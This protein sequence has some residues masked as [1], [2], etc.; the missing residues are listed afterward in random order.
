[1]ADED[2]AVIVGVTRY[3]HMGDLGGPENDARAMIEWL[4]DPTGGAVPHE[5]VY[6]VCTGQFTGSGERERPN[7]RDACAPFEALRAL[8]RPDGQPGRIGRRLYIFFAGHGVASDPRDPALLMANAKWMAWGHSVSGTMV[9]DDFIRG[10]H[11]EEIV[12]LMD[13][14]EDDLGMALPHVLPWQ[15]LAAEGDGSTRYLYGFATQFKCPAREQEVDGKCRGVFTTALLR[16]LRAGPVSSASIQAVVASYMQELLGGH[17]QVPVFHPGGEP[18][19]LGTPTELPV[20]EISVEAPVGDSGLAA[21]SVSNGDGTPP[22]ARRELAPGEVW[23]LALEP[24]LYE[25]VR[26]DNA[27]KELVKIP[28]DT[29]VEL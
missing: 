3:P 7:Q 23:E 1:M 22:F 14:C 18:L 6:A 25:I 29:H 2:H 4:E 28:D 26:E 15:K 12:L 21:V 10:G 17:P 24:K 13:C 16:A 20:L 27:K 8:V 5:H 11:F 9:A 19:T